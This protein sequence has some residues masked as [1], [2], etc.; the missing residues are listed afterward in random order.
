MY[1]HYSKELPTPT[2]NQPA[3]T[4]SSSWVICL[5]KISALL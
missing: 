1:L 5:F 2:S 3:A 4:L